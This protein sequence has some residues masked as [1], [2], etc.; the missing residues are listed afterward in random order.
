MGNITKIETKKFRKLVSV[1]ILGFAVLAV[2]ANLVRVIIVKI[3]MEQGMN[4]YDQY[5]YDIA[6]KNY[7]RAIK[8]SFWNKETKADSFLWRGR[9]YYGKQEFT[10]A[11]ADFTEAIELQK[12][13]YPYYTWRA[14][15]NYKL[16]RYEPAIADFSKAIELDSGGWDKYLERASVYRANKDYALAIADYEQA[17]AALDKSIENQESLYLVGFIDDKELAD[18]IDDLMKKRN[19]VISQKNDIENEIELREKEREWKINNHGKSSL[20]MLFEK[21]NEALDGKLN[22]LLQRNSD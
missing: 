11:R 10:I 12:D 15:T 16:N 7:T 1:I 3:N 2:S 6:I 14:R 21:L 4:A 18:K 19:D 22:E 8:F 20:K 9:A 13:Y 17:I 5:D